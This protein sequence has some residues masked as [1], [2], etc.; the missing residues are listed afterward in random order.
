MVTRLESVG[1]REG[2]DK[3]VEVGEPDGVCWLGG[4]IAEVE[5]DV[6]RRGGG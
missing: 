2:D 4:A 6:R 5:E 1:A 3:W